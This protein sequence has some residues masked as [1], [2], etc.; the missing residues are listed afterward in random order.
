MIQREILPYVPYVLLDGHYGSFH[1][2]DIL[3]NT[4]WC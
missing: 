2:A 3:P 4:R 1:L